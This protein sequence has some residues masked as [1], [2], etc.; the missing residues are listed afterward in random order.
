MS[1]ATHFLISW[2][3]AN[4]DRRTRGDMAAVT[5]AGVAP[6]LDGIGYPAEWLTAGTAHP[7]H[8]YSDYHHVIC[9]GLLACCLY[10]IVVAIWRRRLLTVV[11]SGVAFHLHL[12]CDLAGS[13]GPGGD[14]WPILYL[15][16]ISHQETAVSWQWPL[17]SPINVAIT[18]AFELAMLVIAYRRGFSPLWMVSPRVDEQV[19]A[20][21]RR[22]FAR[23]R[24]SGQIDSGAGP[25]GQAGA[26]RDAD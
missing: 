26:N 5:I 10:L 7:L 8:W 14:S 18:G 17:N 15:W 16:P 4:L 25:H 13:G 21:A 9:H 11:L 1:P 12:T 19:F 3:L 23:Q 24:P 20:I 22:R 6:D 2:S